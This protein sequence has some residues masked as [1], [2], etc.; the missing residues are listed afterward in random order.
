MLHRNTIAFVGMSDREEYLAT[1]VI[2]DRFLAL[3]KSNYL[4]SWDIVTGKL[5]QGIKPCNISEGKEKQD[6]SSF[7]IYSYSSKNH[8]YRQDWANRVLLRSKE[9]V[10][11]DKIDWKQY[12]D[13]SMVKANTKKQKS[14]IESLSKQFY[15]FK[16]VEI[17]DE[18]N[19]KEHFSFIYPNFFRSTALHRKL[20]DKWSD[21]E[22][23]EDEKSEEDSD[24]DGPSKRAPEVPVQIMQYM[25]F[26]TDMNMM[27]EIL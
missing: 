27:L 18:K 10:N 24:E 15:E 17:M 7:E 9:P 25:Y 11:D 12:F 8:A 1:K 21:D 16:Y 3:D 13:A 6:Y 14:F 2:N 5:S 23:N 26:N 22:K 20:A 19:V 4:T